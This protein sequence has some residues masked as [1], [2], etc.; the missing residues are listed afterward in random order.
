MIRPGRE[1]EEGLEEEDAVVVV[2]AEEGVG[3][4]SKTRLIK[5]GDLI[6]RGEGT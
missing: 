6:F 1:A 4:D 3:E 2:V 5:A